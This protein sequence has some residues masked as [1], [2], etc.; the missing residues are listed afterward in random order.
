VADKHSRDVTVARVVDEF[1]AVNVLI[2][3]AG[4]IQ[5]ATACD[6]T[7][8]DW[9]RI[10]SVNLDGV[11]FMSQ[12]VIPFMKKQGGDSIACMSSVSAQRG[13]GILG[14]RT[15]QP[16]RP[17]YLVWPK[18]WRANWASM[19]FASTVSHPD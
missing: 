12:T 14:S 17:A 16:P 8:T 13:G 3:N 5:P 15:I 7:P 6:I 11:L 9:D 2:A 4:I 1:G 19:V 10:L 18:P